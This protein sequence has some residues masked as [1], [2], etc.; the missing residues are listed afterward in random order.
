MIKKNEPL[1]MAEAMEYSKN[2]KDEGKEIQGFIKKFTKLKAKE[3]KEIRKKIKNLEIIKLDDGS[4]SKIIDLVPDNKE[5]L[6]KIFVGFSLDEEESN[7]V[8]EII[9][10]FK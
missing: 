2:S 5:D 9:K 10:E 3:A 8:L 6:N 4:I 7:K 1:S